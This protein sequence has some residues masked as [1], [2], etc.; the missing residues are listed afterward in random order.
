MQRQPDGPGV[1]GADVLDG[2]PGVD[3]QVTAKPA[4]GPRRPRGRL[5]LPSGWRIQT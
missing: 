2:F 5:Y 1:P 3:Q 4:V